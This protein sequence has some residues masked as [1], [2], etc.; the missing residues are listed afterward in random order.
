MYMY[1]HILY[2]VKAY[3]GKKT[4]SGHSVDN[5]HELCLELLRDQQVYLLVFVYVYV[6]IVFV[7]DTSVSLIQHA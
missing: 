1:I 5:A 3:F 4:A 2:Q 6:Y 7:P